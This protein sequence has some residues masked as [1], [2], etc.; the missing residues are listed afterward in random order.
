[1]KSLLF[2]LFM[3]ISVLLRANDT[4]NI[5]PKS[6]FNRWSIGVNISPEYCFR[7]LINNSGSPIADI[8]ID[9]RNG[10]EQFKIGFSAGVV[11]SY[12]I[13]GKTSFEIGLSYSDKGYSTRKTEL[14]FGD[15]IDP[16]YGF[17]YTTSQPG[18]SPGTLAI[19]FYYN[20]IYLDVPLRVLFAFGKKKT[21]YIGGIGITSAILLKST[22]NLVFDDG[23]GSKSVSTND[24]NES[25][26]KFNLFPEVSIGVERQ[27]SRK[28]SVRIQPVF[29]YG[30]LKIIDT[31]VSANLWSGG[32][33]VGCYY[34]L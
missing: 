30:I 4:L 5:I 2:L 3:I 10:Y 1:M 28:V 18:N 13:S 9:S 17:T 21:R 22:Q 14:T 31:P 11:A 15:A 16:R 29:K 33:N 24:Q 20:H 12:N 26:N 34:R 32:V 7:T 19:K 25:F 6:E 23:D 8:V 27:V